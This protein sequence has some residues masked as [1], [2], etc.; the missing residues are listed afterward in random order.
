[1]VTSSLLLGQVVDFIV[2][3]TYGNR[4]LW[5]HILFGGIGAKVFTMLGA[6]RWQSFL[7]VCLIAV[8]W[9]VFEFEWEAKRRPDF[10]YGSYRRWLADSLGDV[11]G[12]VV[13]AGVV[14]I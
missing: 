12:A 3:M 6:S 9:E 2:N 7:I 14:L 11:V 1:M 5:F 13:M 4:W 10:V 8:L